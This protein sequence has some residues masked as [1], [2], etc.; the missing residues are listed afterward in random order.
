MIPVRRLLAVTAFLAV[1]ALL[2]SSDVWGDP[3]KDGKNWQKG[4]KDKPAIKKDKK[5]EELDKNRFV[6]KPVITYQDKDGTYFA[7]QVQP[8][9]PDAPAV[10]TDYLVLVETSASKAT[11]FLA[12]AQKVVSTLVENLGAEDR[13]SLWTANIKPRD[14]SRGFKSGKDLKDAVTALQ[15]EL[16]LG[17]VDMKKCLSEALNGFEVKASRRRVVVYLGDGNSV[18]APVDADSRMALC[19]VMN[20][21]SRRSS[22][23]PWA[24]GPTRRTC[25]D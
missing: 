4:E 25:T 12:V 10:P 14:L 20:I 19:E 7:L 24:S 9:L 8:K 3:D 22:R 23:C 1:A 2:T 18:A 16:P 15:N 6:E 13:L 11:G 5:D 17:A 21:N